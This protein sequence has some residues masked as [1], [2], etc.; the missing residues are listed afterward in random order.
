MATYKGITCENFRAIRHDINSKQNYTNRIPK[1]GKQSFRMTCSCLKIYNRQKTSLKI[2]KR[3]S[4][5]VDTPTVVLEKESD[6]S[7]FVCLVNERPQ[8]KG[9]NLENE[10]PG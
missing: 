3:S 8:V 9:L 7:E 5:T 4:P 6:H 10:F 1:S 2:T